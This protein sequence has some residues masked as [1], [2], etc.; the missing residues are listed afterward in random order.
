MEKKNLSDE[1]PMTEE[2][3]EIYLKL[4]RPEEAKARQ[5]HQRIVKLMQLA[6]KRLDDIKKQRK[7]A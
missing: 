6:E 4:A 5:S 7:Y 3:L 1:V 2:G